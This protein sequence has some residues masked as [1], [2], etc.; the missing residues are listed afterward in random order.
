MTKAIFLILFQAGL[1]HKFLYICLCTE[2]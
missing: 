2:G 1:N